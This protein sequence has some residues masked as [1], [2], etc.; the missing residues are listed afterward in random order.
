MQAITLGTNLVQE[1]AND[2]K[3]ALLLKEKK[4][5]STFVDPNGNKVLLSEENINIDG[6]G[7]PTK[8]T[9]QSDDACCKIC[10]GTE[11]EDIA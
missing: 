7:S 9:E 10:W 1:L 11:K 6:R 5:H 8:L 4:K 3:A 2:K